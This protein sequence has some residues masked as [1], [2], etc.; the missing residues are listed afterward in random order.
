M[1]KKP[2]TLVCSDCG[3]EPEHLKWATIRHGEHTYTGRALV[4]PE[5]QV[6]LLYGLFPW[7][8]N[9][10]GGPEVTV[11]QMFTGVAV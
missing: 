7:V 1:G 4:C 11:A 5:C 2:P 9:P 3:S 10:D 6:E 8:T